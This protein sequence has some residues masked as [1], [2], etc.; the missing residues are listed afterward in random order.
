MRYVVDVNVMI[1]S[2]DVALGSRQLS[3]VLHCA[4]HFYTYGLNIIK[5][6]RKGYSFDETRQ[7]AYRA[8]AGKLAK[9]E[10]LTPA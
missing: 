6:G 4:Q 7:K 8:I 3:Q 5:N 1:N 9:E 2:I 10:K